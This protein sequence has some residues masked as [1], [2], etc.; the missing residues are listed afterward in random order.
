MASCRTLLFGI[1]AA[2][3]DT[4]LT[5][6]SCIYHDMSAYP[7]TTNQATIFLKKRN[8]SPDDQQGQNPLQEHD[9][10]VRRFPTHSA[11][12]GRQQTQGQT[13]GQ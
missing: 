13:R 3:I 5:R 1:F 7:T 12:G 6:Y 10:I 8:A 11:S 4:G 9:K 2:R